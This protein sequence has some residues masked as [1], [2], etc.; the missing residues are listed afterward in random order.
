MKG[1]YQLAKEHSGPSMGCLVL[2]QGTIDQEA[3]ELADGWIEIHHI[4]L[5]SRQI[6]RLLDMLYDYTYHEI[7]HHPDQTLG[8]YYWNIHQLLEAQIESKTV[9][10]EVK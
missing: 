6:E 9:A 7:S 1:L 8:A 2:D 3:G 5:N 10:Q 4:T